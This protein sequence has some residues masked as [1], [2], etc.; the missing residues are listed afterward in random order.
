MLF[1]VSTRVVRLGI[2]C[3]RE[4]CMLEIRFRAS[5]K[6]RNRGDRGKFPRACISLSV[7]SMASSGYVKSSQVS[8]CTQMCE[9]NARERDG[10]CNA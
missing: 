4:G 8:N 2:D 5:S 6:V 1:D 7:K 9:K 3:A 10:D